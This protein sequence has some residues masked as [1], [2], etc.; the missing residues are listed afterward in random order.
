MT[1]ITIMDSGIDADAAYAA[2]EARDRASDGRFVVAVR[3]T[4]IYCKPSCPARRPRREN[5]EF[6]ADTA[7]ARAAG[8]RACLRCRPDE[9]SRDGAAVAKAIRLI[10]ASEERLALEDLARAVGYAPHHFHRLFKR[11]TGL[12]PAAYARGLRAERLARRLDG[13]E[14]SVTR[15]IYAAG[16]EA[17]SRAY[18]DA[19]ARLGMT[20]STWKG[21]GAGETIRHRVV[22]TS[23]GPLLVAATARGLCRIA[24][25][26]DAADLKARFPKAEIA[27]GDEDFAVLVRQ[28]VTMVDH[29][30]RAADLPLD[31]RGTAFQQAVWRALLAIPAGETRS[32]AEIAA[33][34]G[35]PG[36]VRAA[37]SAC[38]GNPLPVVVPCHRVLRGDGGLGGY[39]YGAERKKALLAREAKG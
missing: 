7:A 13:E 12:T 11:G 36:A 6:F 16:Y 28:V 31:M 14:G 1:G 3:T 5:I 19:K 15:A 35:S 26:E 10:E 37:G 30:A 20:P 8:Y 24:F 27:E 9:L 22:A 29:P 34:A 32:Y 23:L 38:G 17:P 18:A 4:G 33:M 21:G 39:A 2:F 25:D